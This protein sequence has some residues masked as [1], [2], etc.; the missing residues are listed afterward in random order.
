MRRFIPVILVVCAFALGACGDP[1]AAP[2]PTPDPPAPEP[3]APVG[4]EEPGETE[5]PSETEEP[6][7]TDEVL[8][9]YVRETDSGSWVEPEVAVLD[10]PTVGVA[11]AAMEALVSRDPLDPGLVSLAGDDAQ[12]L[13]ASI[14]GD[15]LTVDFSNLVPASGLGAAFESLLLQQIAHTGTQFEGI[16]RVQIWVDGEPVESIAGHIEVLDPIEADPLAISPITFT[17]HTTGDTV[18]VGDVTVGGEACTF[19]A[20]VL[21]ELLAPDGTIAEE[22][23]TTATSGCP[24]RGEWDHTFTLNE[25]GTWTIR[26]A[27]SDPS[28]GEG[29][30]PFAVELELEAS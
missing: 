12:V 4:P 28:D 14:D 24:E 16:E 18:D 8:V 19:E 5:D 7:G 10:E 13:G 21:L 27:E 29:R 23:F 17:S 11:R 6:E 3:E 26:A 2:E 1:A 25:P 30:P 20:N 9:F 22:T 15:V